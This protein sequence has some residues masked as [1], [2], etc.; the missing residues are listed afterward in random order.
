MRKTQQVDASSGAQICPP[1]DRVHRG[2]NQPCCEARSLE[3]MGECQ[4]RY[5]ERVEGKRKKG[6]GKK[7]EK[8][9]KSRRRIF[10]TSVP[11]P[12]KSS[13]DED[14]DCWREKA[15]A[16]AEHERTE[17]EEGKTENKTHR[18]RRL[19][20]LRKSGLPEDGS[21]P[22]ATRTTEKRVKFICWN[23]QKEVNSE[24]GLVVFAQLTLFVRRVFSFW[25]GLRFPPVRSRR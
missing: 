16:E 17:R 19:S 2:R 6:D 9:R 23:N 12:R 7:S 13:I 22:P 24:T 18:I 5:S 11:S 4:A 1:I 25:S 15:P 20:L 14:G 10:L 21:R 8:E 3:I